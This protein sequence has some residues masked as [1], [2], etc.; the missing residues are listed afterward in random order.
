MK[1][2]SSDKLKELIQKK[3]SKQLSEL[4]ALEA[5]SNL[6]NYFKMLIEIANENPEI[7]QDNI[8]CHTGEYITNT[9]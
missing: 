1:R 4:D 5:E 8:L 2:K 7:T 9:N 6:L 3:S